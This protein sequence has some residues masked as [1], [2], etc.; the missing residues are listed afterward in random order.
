MK[1]KWVNIDGWR[2]YYIPITPK[3][4]QL[5][6]DCSVVNEA[7]NELKAIMIK[8]LK[9]R[10]IKY[11]SGYLRGSNVFSAHFYMMIENGWIKEDKRKAIDDWFVDYINST[12]SIFSG[13]SW[14]LD[15][16]KAEREFK[17]IIIN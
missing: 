2:G 1:K 17:Q 6:T 4:W 12:F 15:K 11:R 16:K 7:G 5:L 9:F 10:K 13:K 8:W 3:G 14:E